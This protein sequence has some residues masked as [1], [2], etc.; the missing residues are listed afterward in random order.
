MGRDSVWAVGR[1]GPSG[2]LS[3]LNSLTLTER[4]T[5]NLSTLYSI[6]SVSLIILPKLLTSIL[7]PI[8]F[9]TRVFSVFLTVEVEAGWK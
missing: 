5:H 8:V 6:I 2:G 9:Q 3:P 7:I 1:G 4:Q